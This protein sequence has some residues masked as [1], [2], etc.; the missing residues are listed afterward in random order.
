MC[1]LMTSFSSNKNETNEKK[2]SVKHTSETF[3]NNEEKN[4]EEDEK[5]KTSV[6]ENDLM[7]A[8]N[9]EFFHESETSNIKDIDEISSN[10][11][12]K[13]EYLQKI[14]NYE[15]EERK[16]KV[17]DA[18][19]LADE[20]VEEDIAKKSLELGKELMKASQDAIKDV[21]NEIEP[22]YVI[23]RLLETFPQSQIFKTRDAKLRDALDNTPHQILINAI[24]SHP[25][26]RVDDAICLNT[27]Y[28]IHKAISAT[29][30]HQLS[31]DV[32]NDLI[33]IFI[34]WSPEVLLKGLQ[35]VS[36]EAVF[37]TLREVQVDIVKL[38]MK[39][40][41]IDSYRFA[42]S[43]AT[44]SDVRQFMEKLPSHV[45][46]CALQQ[47]PIE[48]VW[49]SLECFSRNSL[50]KASHVCDAAPKAEISDL[51]ESMKESERIDLSEDSFQENVEILDNKEI[52]FKDSEIISKNS[53]SS[54][55]D[56]LEDF[57]KDS[58]SIIKTSQEATN[59]DSNGGND[60]RNLKI[61]SFSFFSF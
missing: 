7:L 37:S 39:I 56:L 27:L 55:P 15:G 34:H 24:R 19:K 47:T 43:Y 31:E 35:L 29:R 16:L 17:F 49:D 60:L 51:K 10:Q 25:S 58:S 6:K 45:L 33:V 20:S 53:S 41:S 30:L 28:N 9:K 21:L 52:L 4:I 38:A 3:L 32:V 23:Q 22:D 40:D 14:S 54:S 1:L 48:I 11:P 59:G 61:C 57:K 42:L 50:H 26:S 12:K 8:Q 44:P 5:S 18:T 36:P 13:I 46:V 2:L